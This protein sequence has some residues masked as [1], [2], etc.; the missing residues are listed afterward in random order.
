MSALVY[1]FLLLL[2]FLLMYFL[3]YHNIFFTIQNYKS[4]EICVV[5]VNRLS[6]FLYS[7]MYLAIHT[8]FSLSL[9]SSTKTYHKSDKDR[10]IFV[11]VTISVIYAPAASFF[12]HLPHRFLVRIST[13]P[14]RRVFWPTLTEFEEIVSS[15]LF[16]GLLTI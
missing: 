9:A 4:H 1:F 15:P 2:F 11:K 7:Q 5:D 3:F 14:S 16:Y 10:K 12:N 8:F 6:L 13:A